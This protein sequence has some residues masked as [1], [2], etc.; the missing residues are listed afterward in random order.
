MTATRSA[1]LATQGEPRRLYAVEMDEGAYSCGDRHAEAPSENNAE[2]GTKDRGTRGLCAHDARNHQ[3]H[4]RKSDD[5]PRLLS[6]GRR[7]CAYERYKATDD[8]TCRGGE[9]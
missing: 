3:A 1:I 9:G 2:G 7:K 8:E 5:A 4:Y 6:S